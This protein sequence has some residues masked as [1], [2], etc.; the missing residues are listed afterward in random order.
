MVRQ[1]FLKLPTRDVA[2]CCCVS[3]LWR[4]V[5]ADPSFRSFHA[6]TEASHVSTASEA[7]LV[8]ET[9]NHGQQWPATRMQAALLEVGN[10]VQSR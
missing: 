6:K 5:V 7:L 1:I 9:R 2:S 3:R 4:D 8:T 10:K